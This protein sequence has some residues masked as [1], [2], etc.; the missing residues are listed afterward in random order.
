VYKAMM[1]SPYP[2]RT[3]VGVSLRGILVEISAV[4]YLPRAT[5]GG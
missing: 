5:T 3:A 4:A 2:S 1:P